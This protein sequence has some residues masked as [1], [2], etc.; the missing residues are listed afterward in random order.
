MRL[1]VLSAF[2]GLVLAVAV[3]VAAPAHAAQFGAVAY[4]KATGRAGL[5]AHHDSLRAAER[6]ALHECH[7]HGCRIVLKFG[8]Q[9]CAA[10]ATARKGRAWGASRR[11]SQ[12]EA[13]AGALRDCDKH[14]S[15][16]CVVRLAGCND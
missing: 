7:R 5:S 16:T 6:A 11:R 9:S 12:K 13:R 1:S 3:T 10:L 14:A 4:D 15:G 8:P 2:G